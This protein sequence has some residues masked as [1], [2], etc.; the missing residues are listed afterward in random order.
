MISTKQRL[1]LVRA[2][3]GTSLIRAIAW[4][5][6]LGATAVLVR[7]EAHRASLPETVSAHL[8]IVYRS[9][10]GREVRLDV[11]LPTAPGPRVGRPAVVAIHGGGWRGGSKRDL[12]P[13]A[14]QLAERGYVVVAIDYLL[15]RPG[16]PS[17]PTNF[18]DTQEAI[19][20][21][22]RHAADYGINSG[23]IAALGVSAGGHLAALLGTHPDSPVDPD[24]HDRSHT[25]ASGSLSD[26]SARV[27]AVVDFYGPADLAAPQSSLTL[28][29]TPVSLLIGGTFEDMAGRLEAASPVTHVSSDDPP[30]LLIHGR[31]DRLVPLDQSRAFASRL[32][33]AGV[34][35]RLIEVDDAAHGF[36]FHVPNRN[37]LP[38][39]LAFLDSVWNSRAGALK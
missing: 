5:V 25:Q 19:R 36:G 35:H 38:E 7:A 33:K 12:K 31:D 9:I 4:L 6:L 15:S 23:Q 32:D 14:I 30:M 10:A 21:V 34:V 28:P 17:W 26:V 1:Q 22:R 27:Q 11:Y 29:S 37:L 20:W 18:E 13:M 3:F 24:A 39:I 8:D 2:P 16:R